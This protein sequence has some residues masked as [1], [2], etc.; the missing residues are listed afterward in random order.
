MAIC[1]RQLRA[2]IAGG[3]HLPGQTSP[4]GAVEPSPVPGPHLAIGSQS[5]AD[6][7]GIWPTNFTATALYINQDIDKQQRKHPG[8]RNQEHTP[9]QGTIGHATK[10][11]KGRLQRPSHTCGTQEPT[12]AITEP[13]PTDAPASG[14]NI[15]VNYPTPTSLSPSDLHATTIQLFNANLVCVQHMSQDQRDIGQERTQ[16]RQRLLGATTKS[17]QGRLKQPMHTELTH[18]KNKPTTRSPPAME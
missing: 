1:V 17:H 13:K 8:R 7:R 5:T 14:R 3:S 15:Q 11:L 12:K 6:I 2:S 18:A 10:S 9:Q 4:P 16:Q